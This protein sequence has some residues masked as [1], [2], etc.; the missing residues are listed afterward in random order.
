MLENSINKVSRGSEPTGNH[1]KFQKK[2][3]L[4]ENCFIQITY[5]LFLYRV[6][7]NS[8]LSISASETPS[9]RQSQ[10]CMCLWIC[11]DVLG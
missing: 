4:L 10:N 11:A 3:L 6:I 2:D 7:M 9:L 5:V 1:C 8:V